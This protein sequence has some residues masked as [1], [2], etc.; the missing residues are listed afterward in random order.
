[1]TSNQEYGLF[2]LKYIAAS[3]F[4]TYVAGVVHPLDLIKTRFQSKTLFISGHDGKGHDNLVPK[5]SGINNAL[6]S[7][8]KSEGLRGLYK[9]FYISLLC[10]ATSMSVFFWQYTSPYPAMKPARVASN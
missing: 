10:Q 2:S 9:G 5:Y 7:I 4:A 6:K 3:F 8:Y 1:M